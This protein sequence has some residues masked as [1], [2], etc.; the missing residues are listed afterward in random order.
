MADYKLTKQVLVADTSRDG[1]VFNAV[2]ED[3]DRMEAGP[4]YVK[5]GVLVLDRDSAPPMMS[6]FDTGE[7]DAFSERIRAAE[8]WSGTRYFRWSSD[9][10]SQT[11]YVGGGDLTE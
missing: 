8:T 11:R 4:A 3:M 6:T 5:D 2:S 7:A 9:D 10:E 1:L